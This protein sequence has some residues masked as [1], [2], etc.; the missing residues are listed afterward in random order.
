M[1]RAGDGIR[2]HVMVAWEATALPLGDTRKVEVIIATRGEDVKISANKN[3]TYRGSGQ[4]NCS[5][6]EFT[7][8]LFDCLYLEEGSW[9]ILS[10][11]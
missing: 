11:Q 2:T 3:L 6:V 5:Q 1:K 9:L 8:A 10:L 7:L 4:I